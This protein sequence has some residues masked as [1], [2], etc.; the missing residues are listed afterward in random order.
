MSSPNNKNIV[1]AANQLWGSWKHPESSGVFSILLKIAS[2][3]EVWFDPH[4]GPSK[5]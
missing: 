1:L 4:H 2:D 3:L 5:P